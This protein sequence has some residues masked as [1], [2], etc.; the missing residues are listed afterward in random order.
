MTW[1]AEVVRR[2]N[3]GLPMLAGAVRMSKERLPGWRV[4]YGTRS[5]CCIRVSC[6]M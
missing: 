5:A 6:D 1:L 4:C 2:E 3:G